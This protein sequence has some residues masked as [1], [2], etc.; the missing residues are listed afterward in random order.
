[1][2]IEKFDLYSLKI[3]S[4]L[5]VKSN[6]SDVHT[7]KSDKCLTYFLHFDQKHCNEEI[8]RIKEYQKMIRISPIACNIDFHFSLSQVLNVNK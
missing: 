6:T 7:L 5:L 2:E 8:N 4:D 1:M 3:Y